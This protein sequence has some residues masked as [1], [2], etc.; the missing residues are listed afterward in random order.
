MFTDIQTS[1]GDIKEELLLQ[2]F[3]KKTDAVV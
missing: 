1:N 2:P 3:L